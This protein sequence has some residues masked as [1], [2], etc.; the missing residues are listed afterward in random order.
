[1]KLNKQIL[2]FAFNICNKDYY[3][4]LLCLCSGGVDSIAVAHF[5]RYNQYISRNYNLSVLHINHNY[6]PQNEEM[7][8]SVKQFCADHRIFM[9]HKRVHHNSTRKNFSE[10]YLRN[11]RNDIINRHFSNVLQ[12]TAI[13]TGHHLDDCVESYLLN[14]IRGHQNYNPMSSITK[15]DNYVLARPFILNTKQ[16]FIDYCNR[17]DLMKYVVEDSTNSESKG[18][19]RNM[20]RNEIVPILNRDNVGIRKIVKKIVTR[21]I[22]LDLIKY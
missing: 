6:R 15:F 2:K 3:K 9:F 22:S 7:M 19:R 13:I 11:C 10:D 4:S 14:C 18:S 5:L 20:I 12:N 8:F 16:D 17:H 21:R 1:M